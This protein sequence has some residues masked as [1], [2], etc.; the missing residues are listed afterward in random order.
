MSVKNSLKAAQRLTLNNLLFIF[1]VPKIKSCAQTFTTYLGY[2]TCSVP[3]YSRL[4]SKQA[5]VA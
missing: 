5:P 3:Y 1:Y 2:P 4:Q